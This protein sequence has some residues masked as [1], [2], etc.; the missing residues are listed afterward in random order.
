MHISAFSSVIALVLGVASAQTTSCSNPSQ[1]QEWRELSAAQKTAYINAVVCLKR[2]PSRSRNTGS[3]SR[4]DDF[5]RTHSLVTQVA[6]SSP[7]FLPWHRAY[8]FA[9]EDALKR[10]CGY[11]GSLPYW[12]WSVDSQA[13][14]NSVIWSSNAFGGDGSTSSPN[15]CVTTGS[16]A[17]FVSTFGYQ[18]CLARAFRNS[19]GNIA[20]FF[21]PESIFVLININTSYSAFRTRLESGPHNNVHGGIGRTMA[22]PRVSANDPIFMMHHSNVDR[23]WYMWQLKNPSLA[24]TYEGTLPSSAPARTRDMLPLFNTSRLPDYNVSMMLNTRSGSPLCYTYSNSVRAGS[25][26]LVPPAAS[27]NVSSFAPKKRHMPI[28]KPVRNPV[29]SPKDIANAK[30]PFKFGKDHKITPDTS[31]RSDTTKLRCPSRISDEMIANMGLNATQV[32]EIRIN[33]NQNC[34]FLNYVNSNFPY[35]ESAVKMRDADGEQTFHSISDYEYEFEMNLYT[36]LYSN[37]MNDTTTL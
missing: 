35:Y 18:R 1:R 33:E 10:D 16:F 26:P 21:T 28:I 6:H 7:A 29:V 34:A 25:A 8:L 5:A 12:D 37:Y 23:L 19:L 31:D 3:P 36:Q 4:F 24:N 22:D 27:R 14:E 30:D 20:S 2:T 11:Q 32:A 9:Y 13:P 17:G 15:R